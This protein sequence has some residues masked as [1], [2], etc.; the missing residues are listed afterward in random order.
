MGN[1]TNSASCV[2]SG[3]ALTPPCP[4]PCVTGTERA[5]LRPGEEQ[6]RP[7]GRVHATLT[8]RLLQSA[9]SQASWALL[10]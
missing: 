5:C 7:R 3:E 8:C 1:I 2:T 4:L 10:S 6:I 9:D